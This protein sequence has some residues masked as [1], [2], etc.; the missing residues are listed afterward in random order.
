MSSTQVQQAG[1]LV[2]KY[3]AL[4]LA[5][6]KNSAPRKRLLEAV[7]AN[8]AAVA[9]VNSKI[10]SLPR[11]VWEGIVGRCT[12]PSVD[13]SFNVEVVEDLIALDTREE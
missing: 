1:R 9:A 13:E 7:A 4:M 12:N 2:D 5:V 10:F 3:T 8:P 11:D 6:H